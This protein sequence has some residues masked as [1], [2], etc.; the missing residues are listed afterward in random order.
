MNG[1]AISRY[2]TNQMLYLTNSGM[3]RQI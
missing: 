3:I 1:T 2:L